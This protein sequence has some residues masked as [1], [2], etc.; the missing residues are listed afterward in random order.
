MQ[1]RGWQRSGPSRSSTRSWGPAVPQAW[2]PGGMRTNPPVCSQNQHAGGTQT[3]WCYRGSP[4]TCVRPQGGDKLLWGRCRGL[5]P[6][7]RP[8]A[9][10]QAE[11]GA[12][13]QTWRSSQHCF[14]PEMLPSVWSGV[15]VAN[16]RAGGPGGAAVGES[17]QPG[18]AA[19]GNGGTQRQ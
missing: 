16:C 17:P 3:C 8:G 4:C 19:P 14:G 9:C 6:V 2:G 18:P 12:P 15:H 7:R 10:D 11:L 1:S 5:H 13:S